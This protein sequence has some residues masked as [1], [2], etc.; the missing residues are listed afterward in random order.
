VLLG[1]TQPRVIVRGLQL[2]V[3]SS[4]AV[5]LAVS[6]LE[7]TDGT[8]NHC[9]LRTPAANRRPRTNGEPRTHS[10]VQTAN[11]ERTANREHCELQ[12]AN[13]Q[14][15]ANRE[16]ELL[17]ANCELRTLDVGPSTR[18]LFGIRAVYRSREE[19]PETGGR[20][21]V[22]LRSGGYS[23]SDPQQTHRTCGRRDCAD[24]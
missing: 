20:R 5:Q 3:C 12:T 8:E 17:T 7:S 18:Y 13:R 22:R 15:T 14:R 19:G 10:E 21:S 4:L 2:A 24:P 11:R 9:Q 23:P 16:P 6:S 1:V